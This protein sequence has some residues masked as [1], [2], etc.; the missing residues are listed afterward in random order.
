M[1]VTWHSRQGAQRRSNNDAAAIGYTDYGLVAV[2]VDAAEQGDGAQFARHWA[3]SIVAATRNSSSP[4]D[5]DS[6]RELISAEQEQLRS[7][8]TV[9]KAAYCCVF[10]DLSMHQ[11]EVLYAGDCQLGILKTDGSV[12][13]MTVPHT[14]SRQAELLGVSAPLDARHVLTRCLKVRRSH[15]PDD[16]SF[17]YAQAERLIIC[18]DGHWYESHATIDAMA[19]GSDDASILTLQPG[20][21]TQDVISDCKNFFCYDHSEQSEDA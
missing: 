15:V 17:A 7:K 11:V 4:L 14:L 10:V 8:F 1:H 2:V 12:T 9:E 18:T 6:L 20:G 19:D 21:R 16:C 5:G 13:W 3:T